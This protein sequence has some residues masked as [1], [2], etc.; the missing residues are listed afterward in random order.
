[1]TTVSPFNKEYTAQVLEQFW[2]NY[3]SKISP[4]PTITGHEV[5]AALGFETQQGGEYTWSSPQEGIF[6]LLADKGG[7][8]KM[9]T[10][11]ERKRFNQSTRDQKISI[12]QDYFNKGAYFF[13]PC[14]QGLSANQRIILN[15]TGNQVSFEVIEHLFNNVK[16]KIKV[17]KWYGQAKQ[18]KELQIK[19][20]KVVIYLPQKYIEEV[21]RYCLPFTSRQ[22]LPPFCD[23][24]S[25]KRGE[26]EDFYFGLA[27]EI[28]GTSHLSRCSL[29]IITFLCGTNYNDEKKVDDIKISLAKAKHKYG[30]ERERFIEHCFDYVCKHL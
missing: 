16:D 1:M 2:T 14:D 6:E 23:L 20:D 5:Y 3:I 11:E 24:M 26:K 7:Y 9:M 8:P 13:L 21:V 30:M 17:L 15:T 22:P 12:L 10:L 25:E 4:V 28:Q 19:I 18:E 27:K 29:R